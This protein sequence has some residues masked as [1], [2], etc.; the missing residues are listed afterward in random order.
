MAQWQMVCLPIFSPWVR[1]IPWRRKWQPTPTTTTTTYTIEN[2]QGPTVYSVMA[3]PGIEPR[4]PTLQA[5]A[6]TSEPPG[7]LY[8]GTESK[9]ERM[10]VYA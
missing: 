1:K 6:L 2:K 5:D 8:M 7:K 10:C 3:Y 9:K 4:S